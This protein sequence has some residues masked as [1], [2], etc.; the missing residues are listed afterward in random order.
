VE[1]ED[2]ADKA[3]VESDGFCQDQ[4]SGAYSICCVSE[5]IDEERMMST[6]C[7]I[8]SGWRPYFWVPFSALTGTS[9]YDT[10]EINVRSKADGMASLILRTAQKRKK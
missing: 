7:V 4:Y 5:L 10:V 8:V 6:V 3:E 9:W 2:W 1:K